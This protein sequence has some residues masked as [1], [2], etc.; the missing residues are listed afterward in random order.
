MP[1]QTP[2]SDEQRLRIAELADQGVSVRGIAA[3]LKIAPS[4]V[5]HVGRRM[6]L[7]FD[8]SATAAATSARMTD[9][10]ARRAETA[11]RLLEVANAEL[12]RL[13]RPYRAHAFVGGQAAGY[14]EHVLPQPDVSARLAIARTA[15]TCSTSTSD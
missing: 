8:H 10:K 15:A 6:G 14:L 13:T 1:Q 4:T 11:L 5:T 9:A 12:D 3:R 2:L 7:S